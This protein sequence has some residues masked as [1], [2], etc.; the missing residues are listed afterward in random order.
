MNNRVEKVKHIDWVNL[1][2]EELCTFV[3]LA[4]CLTRGPKAMILRIDSMKKKVVNTMLRYFRTSLYV[5]DAS[6]NWSQRRQCLF[7]RNRFVVKRGWREGTFIIS[8]MVLS[9]IRA[10]MLYSKGGDTTNCH[11]RYW[12]LNLFF[13]MWRV[14][15]RVLMTKSIQALCRRQAKLPLRH[16]HPFGTLLRT[17]F[18]P[19]PHSSLSYSPPSFYRPVPGR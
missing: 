1:E 8:T 14:R 19:S 15:G 12:K 10:M 5:C 17:L 2:M 16:S 9:A 7:N 18:L 3:D 4:L 13:G 6:S 11:M